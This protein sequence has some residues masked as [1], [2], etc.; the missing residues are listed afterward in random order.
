VSATLG[1]NQ[2]VVRRSAAGGLSIADQA[3]RAVRRNRFL[4]SV[5]SSSM[6]GVYHQVNVEREHCSCPGNE[7]AHKFDHPC[8]HVYAVWL[9]IAR[10][11]LEFE[12]SPD[13]ETIQSAISDIQ[14]NAELLR[15]HRLYNGRLSARYS[16]YPNSRR[17]PGGSIG[18][19]EKA[20][21]SLSSVERRAI[22]YALEQLKFDL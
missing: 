18:L 1:Q 14:S 21:R 22:L 2:S 11:L 4:W 8:R 10:E 12:G 7:T 3:E 19:A 5:P 16:S 13:G 17:T 20:R 9:R 15:Y 6:P